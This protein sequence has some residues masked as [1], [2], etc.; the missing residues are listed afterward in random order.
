MKSIIK[1]PALILGMQINSEKNFFVY[2]IDLN[3]IYFFA[4]KVNVWISGHLRNGMST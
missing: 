2:F 1:L 4:L 3:F